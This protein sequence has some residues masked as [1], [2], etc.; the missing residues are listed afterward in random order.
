MRFHVSS[1]GL[2]GTLVH[3]IVIC[4]RKLGK[5]MNRNALIRHFVF[6]FLIMLA[7]SI[8]ALC[9]E[10]HDADK[11]GDLSKV[12]ALP[13]NPMPMLKENHSD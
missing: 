8:P 4:F 2:R 5:A 3:S 13:N 9:G 12:H 7:L 10:I 1:N 11:A 6:A